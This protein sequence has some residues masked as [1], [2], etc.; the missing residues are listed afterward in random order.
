M[1]IRIAQ[2]NLQ[3]AKTETVEVRNTIAERKIDIYLTQEPYTLKGKILGIGQQFAIFIN[4]NMQILYR[5]NLSTDQIT[6]I[7]I[8]KPKP[9]YFISASFASSL[10][11][12]TDII[13]LQ[14]TL[15]KLK[16][17]NIMLG[18]DTNAKS[19][20]WYSTTEDKRVEHMETFIGR[21]YFYILNEQT[22]LKTYDSIHGKSNIDLTLVTNGIINNCQNWEIKESTSDHNLITLEIQDKQ[23]KI[24]RTKIIVY[25]HFKK[26]KR[27]REKENFRNKFTQVT[28]EI[29]NMHIEDK[30]RIVLE[31]IREF[32]KEV[33]LI[34]NEYHQPK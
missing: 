20:L 16:G 4:K 17:K 10:D 2:Q 15:D 5:D 13:K 19:K 1:I 28:D 12:H 31:T 6:V 21:N 18:I 11:I 29:V 32:F 34:T 26:V 33:K 30:I 22:Y 25:K 14:Y 27:E 23:N 9:I 7:M 3:R 8:Q 24:N